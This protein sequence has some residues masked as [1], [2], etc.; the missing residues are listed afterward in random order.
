MDRGIWRATVHGVA[1]SDTTEWLSTH[2]DEQLDVDTRAR[3]TGR[4]TE[5]TPFPGKSSPSAS[6]HSPAPKLSKSR[7]LKVFM[8][9]P[10]HSH[11][12]SLSESLDP[13]A[14]PEDGGWGTKSQTYNHGV[15]LPVP[16]PHTE[17]A[18]E[19]TESCV[20]RTKTY[21]EISRGSDTLS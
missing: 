18:Q 12:Q 6:T 3:H 8:E 15:V 2:T 5:P 11:D 21:W 13:L 20:I 16:R 17:G 14:F 1:E 4:G 7:T 10:A 19:P 9:A